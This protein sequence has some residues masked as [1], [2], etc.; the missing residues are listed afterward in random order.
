MPHIRK[1]DQWLS[2][3]LKEPLHYCPPFLY[4]GNLGPKSNKSR[5]TNKTKGKM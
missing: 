4:A 1:L 2:Q 3:V 5:Q